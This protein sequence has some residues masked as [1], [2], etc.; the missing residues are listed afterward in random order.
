M[1][2]K[3]QLKEFKVKPRAEKLNLKEPKKEWYMCCFRLGPIDK[4]N[5]NKI[6]KE[7]NN[8]SQKVMTNTHVIKALIKYGL[9]V[10]KSHLMRSL[11]EVM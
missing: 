9:K 11:G 6:R 10:D 4:S 2:K 1:A 3:K 7:M 8:Y 5:L